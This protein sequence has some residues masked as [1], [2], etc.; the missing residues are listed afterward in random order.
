MR[1][2]T[3]STAASRIIGDNHRLPSAGGL[4]MQADLQPGLRGG[5][6]HCPEVVDDYPE[7]VPVT[8]RELDVI[9]SYLG[10]LLDELLKHTS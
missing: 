5:A 10:P 9:E 8:Q 6:R 4:R 7:I 2:K 3:S 1:R